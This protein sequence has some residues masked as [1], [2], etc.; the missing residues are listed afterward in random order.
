MIGII[1]DML[2]GWDITQYQNNIQNLHLRNGT[3]EVAEYLIKK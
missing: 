2:A 3:E 1:K